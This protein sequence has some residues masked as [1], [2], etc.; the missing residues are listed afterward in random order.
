MV[1][2]VL[3]LVEIEGHD[4]VLLEVLNLPLLVDELALLILKFL[5]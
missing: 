3:L 4:V 5:L 2:G 1:K